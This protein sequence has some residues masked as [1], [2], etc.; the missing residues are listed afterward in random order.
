MGNLVRKPNEMLINSVVTTSGSETILADAAD[1]KVLIKNYGYIK[2]ANCYVDGV[3]GKCRKIISTSG[4]LSKAV[5]N[6]KP[7]V[8]AA[9][10]GVIEDAVLASLIVEK[11]SKLDG[12]QR[13]YQ[14]EA[15]AYTGVV[16]VPNVASAAGVPATAD[17]DDIVDQIVDAIQNDE[18][19]EVYAG[20]TK[21]VDV[22]DQDAAIQLDL[23]VDG[24]GTTAY[25]GADLDAVV[26]NINAGTQAYAW[27]EDVDGTAATLYIVPRANAA[28]TTAGHDNCADSTTYVDCIGIVSKDVDV[29]I[30]VKYDEDEINK[31]AKVAGTYPIMSQEDI[32]RKFS[33]K[34]YQFG[35]RPNIPLADTD[36][37]KYTFKVYHDSYALDGMN[38]VDNYW[39]HLH[40]Y[41]A[42]TGSNISNWDTELKE[43]GFTVVE[44]SDTAVTKG[45]ATL[46]LTG[47][48]G[49]GAGTFTVTAISGLTKTAKFYAGASNTGTINE[50]TGVIANGTDGDIFYAEIVYSDSATPVVSK[51]TCTAIATGSFTGEAIALSAYEYTGGFKHDI[52]GTDGVMVPV[53]NAAYHSLLDLT[54]ET[55]VWSGAPANTGTIDPVTG[56][57]ASVTAADVFYRTVKYVELTSAIEHKVTQ[58]NPIADTESVAV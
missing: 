9:S 2:K 18:Y 10:G 51:I 35:S 31:L 56:V 6:I 17:I 14:D 11:V 54:I 32:Q 28:I 38:H 39:E 48:S 26:A 44:D 30:N 5:V 50:T 47:A 34:S 4:V 25:D 15:K 40:V 55:E 20:E 46:T 41:V 36:Y 53:G 58:P 45:D 8:N 16:E 1:Y 43:A 13:N 37:V 12:H 3:A 21:I 33:I 19:A 49:A 24:A 27:Q 22:T 57:T 29:K 42:D 7:K 52:T 23:L